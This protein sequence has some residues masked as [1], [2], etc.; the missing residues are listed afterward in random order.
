V[1]QCYRIQVC[2]LRVLFL[3]L[4]RPA[5]LVDVERRHRNASSRA[6]PCY[7]RQI[8]DVCPVSGYLASSVTELNQ[9]LYG[10]KRAGAIST[11]WRLAFD[12][13]LLYLLYSNREII[14][15]YGKPVRSLKCDDLRSAGESDSFI[16]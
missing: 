5:E 15:V 6:S 14:V 10:G 9:K 7:V 8:C 4:L 12:V 3:S 13:Y 11:S 16:F 1:L 2:T